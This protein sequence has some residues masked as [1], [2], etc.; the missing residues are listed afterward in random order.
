M[1]VD[2][3]GGAGCSLQMFDEEMQSLFFLIAFVYTLNIISNCFNIHTT[4]MSRSIVYIVFF[5]LKL[6]FME[7]LCFYI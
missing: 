7:L 6:L 3:D 4:S 2:G 5:K 1:D